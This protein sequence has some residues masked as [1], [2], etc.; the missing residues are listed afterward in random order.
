[1]K[2]KLVKRNKRN[3]SSINKL[4][5]CLLFHMPQ[6]SLTIYIHK[7]DQAWPFTI[8]QI[9]FYHLHPQDR[10]IHMLP[11]SLHDHFQTIVFTHNPTLRKR[12][13]ILQKAS[14]IRQLWHK[15]IICFLHIEFMSQLFAIHF[16]YRHKY[17]GQPSIFPPTLPQISI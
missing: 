10:L 1:M 9:K 17:S 6:T 11:A 3:M 5:S 7:T 2:E 12:E 13:N 16:K 4:K 14:K 8:K 15:T